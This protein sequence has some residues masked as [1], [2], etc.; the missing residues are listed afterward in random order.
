MGNY[1]KYKTKMSFH[2]KVLPLQ[3]KYAGSHTRELKEN[4]ISGNKF[5]NENG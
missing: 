4:L 5:E 3:N 2:S 1:I